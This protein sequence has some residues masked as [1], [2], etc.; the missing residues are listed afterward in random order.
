MTL[1]RLAQIIDT[2][3]EYHPAERICVRAA[4]TAAG[5]REVELG[6]MQN[7]AVEDRRSPL[8]QA[9]PVSLNAA[10]RAGEAGRRPH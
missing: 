6:R 4:K 2:A 9:Q 3:I 10:C 8:Q 7:D 5:G 1:A